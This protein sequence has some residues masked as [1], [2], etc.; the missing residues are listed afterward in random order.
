[1]IQAV[2][3]LQITSLRNTLRER[4]KRLRQPRYLFGALAGL[5]YFYLF[6]LRHLF[7]RGRGV[8]ALPIDPQQLPQLLEPIAA[9]VL[10]GFVILCWLLPSGRAS[11]LFSEAEVAFLF[12]APVS[13]RSLI[14]YKLLK[15]QL[16][17]LITS[18][19][20]SLISRRWDVLGGN[21]LM[22]AIGWWLIFSF[23]SLH[24]IAA[25]FTCERLFE[26][27]VNA[28]RRRI[29]AFAGVAVTAF[30]VVS[31]IRSHL[32]G[33]EATDLVDATSILGF[34][35]KVLEAPPLGW[36]ILPFRWVVR[37]FL[38]QDLAAFVQALGPIAL[39]IALQY[40]WVIRSNVAF[41]ESSLNAAQKRAE[42]VAALRSGEWRTRSASKNAR[43]EPFRLRPS[44][45]PA[46]ALLWN[47]LIAVGP[48]YY[49]RPWAVAAIVLIGLERWLVSHSEYQPFIQLSFIFT[50][51]IASYALLL[52]PLLVR[53]GSQRLMQ[54]LDTM[55]AYPLRGSQIIFGE[56]LSPIVL[57]SAAEW[58]ALGIMAIALSH[59]AI[60]MKD[61]PTEVIVA[62]AIGAGLVIPPIVGLMFGLNYLG[63]LYFP[64]WMPTATQGAGVERMGQGLIFMFAYLVMMIACVA[65]AAT[66]ALVAVLL[67][68]L[69]ADA[70]VLGIFLAAILAAVVLAGELYAFIWFLGRRYEAF[71]LTAELPR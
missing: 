52:G 34:I 51:I 58:I 44:G 5:A 66:I 25:S 49:A 33:L 4:F 71:D 28:K 23:G 65:P 17:I 10:L 68:K 54:R 62:S 22:H 67:T 39:I 9:F 12:P 57:L 43:P 29:I 11:L 14:H 46:P 42:T 59:G 70:L 27:G 60:H 6:I 64:A 30:V 31:W 15:S 35:K 55:K 26:V 41:E 47:N 50:A 69:L 40:L 21:L 53:R 7:H 48:R 18:L 61:V 37:P 38:A 45:P 20:L 36:F 32:P 19:I 16:G 56:L 13:R 8:P 24:G 2:L 63:I 1:M 3:Y